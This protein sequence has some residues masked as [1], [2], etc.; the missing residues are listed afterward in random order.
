MPLHYKGARFYRVIDKFIDQTGIPTES[1]YGGQ[2]ADDP[3]AL[4]LKHDR[5][6]EGEEV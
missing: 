1:I 4:K 6:R 2:F 5:V 3:A